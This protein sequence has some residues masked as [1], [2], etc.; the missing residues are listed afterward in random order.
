MH[1]IKCIY[2][3]LLSATLLTMSIPS[4]NEAAGFSILIIGDSN[5]ENGFISLALADTLHRYF[6]VDV[7]GTGYI[8]L[9]SSFYALRN[10]R[11]PGV[12]I[13]YNASWT[14]MDM[15][16]GT[17]LAAVPYLSP[18]G[19]W[20][21]SSTA[22]ATVTIAFPGNGVDIYWLSQSTGGVFSIT[23]DGTAYD[24]V[25]T[26]GAGAASTHKT[27]IRGLSNSSHTLL[28]KVASVPSQ[29]NVTLLG[30]DARRDIAGQNNRCAVH[31]WG[32]GYC[33]TSDFL[34]IDSTIFV[35]ALQEL[36]PDVV[37][38]LLGTNDYYIDQRSAAD[39]KTNLKAITNRVKA[40]VV[41]SQ[42][43]L[44]STFMTDDTYGPTYLPLYRATSWPQAASETDSRYWDMSVWFGA[45]NVKNMSGTM[46]CNAPGG[47]LIA[48]EMLHQIL[49]Q[50]PAT[51]VRGIRNIPM[52][53]TGNPIIRIGNN[54]IL[55][56]KPEQPL[57]IDLFAANGRCV[58]HIKGP[59]ALCRIGE[60]LPAGAFI[61]ALHSTDLPY[62]QRLITLLR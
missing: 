1:T 14:K 26:V 51:P 32:N 5:T 4:T 29:G 9:D 61:A 40:S 41:V 62:A 23:I 16:E 49:V 8:P 34:K 37:V 60:V 31:N 20:L 46:H 54:V 39:F 57:Q 55:A 42:I 21:K 47:R 30:F 36:M 12:S 50:F 22:G 27:Q 10:K 19:Q 58:E 53:L 15:N 33:T 56:R 45:Y 52:K 44:V 28:I 6:N 17:R 59:G 25:S 7:M 35:T 43:M 11:Y 18:N 48:N 38:V 2:N 24:T 13:G 3:L